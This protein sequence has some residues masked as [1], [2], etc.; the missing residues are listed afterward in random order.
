MKTWN[1]TMEISPLDSNPYQ[2]TGNWEYSEE[3]N[4]WYLDGAS[5]PD[6]I[7]RKVTE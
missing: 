5:Y 3:W 6:E 7:C 2:L 4:C 1:G